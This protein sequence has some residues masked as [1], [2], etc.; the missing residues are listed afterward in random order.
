[1]L[2]AGSCDWLEVSPSNEVNEEDLFAKGS[3][4]RNALNG[5][6]LNMSDNS[7]YGR[8]L[9][10]GFIEVLGHQYLPEH[11]KN[12]GSYYKTY[13]FL[14]DDTDVKSFISAMWSKGYNVIASCNNLIHNISEA[15][16]MLFDG[17]EMEKNMIWGEA[18]AL[19]ALMHFEL[20]RMFA[21]SMEV[22]DGK[23]YIPYVDEYPVINTT[24]YTNAEILKKIEADFKE[25]RRL[26]AMCDVEQHPEWM[27][28][29]VRMRGDGVTTDLPDDV[30]YAF[31]GYRMNYYAITAWMARMYMWA[32]DYDAAFSCSEEVINSTYK[33]RAYF[34][35]INSAELSKDKKDSKSL[36]FTISHNNV[37]TDEYKPFTN[38][39]SENLFLFSK[40]DIYD[41]ELEKKEDVRGKDEMLTLVTGASYCS[42][43]YLIE[44]GT[45][46]YDMIPMLRL[47]EL[48]YIVGE[49]Y[50]RN[51][52]L[53]KA[54]AA[55]DV[56]RRARGLMLALPE[57]SSLDAFY[58]EM[59]KEMRKELIGEGQLYFL[60]KR[61]NMKEPFD[62]DE[63]NVNFV[64]E[65][66]EN[67]DI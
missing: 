53:D 21:P 25:A 61:L 55:L 20:L 39:G 16:A 29:D 3:G 57:P 67:E 43:K 58:K 26:V 52:Q 47:S 64:F 56:V 33:D 19:R 11:L 34:D 46:G 2:L 38:N 10:Y 7:L 22:D 63:K 28:Y 62:M 4:Y 45:I 27:Q 41:E 51:N 32:K 14:Y 44:E 30:F 18:L 65:H 48:Y 50:A 6:Y 1:M 49:Y 42:R 59:I 54:G 8:N 35:F 24:Y 37:L 66:P 12:T 31:R 36:I 9:S 5:I 15:D 17:V 60:Y 23:A 13:Q 40:D